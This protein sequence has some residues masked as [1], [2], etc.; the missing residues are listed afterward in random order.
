MRIFYFGILN[1]TFYTL[2]EEFLKNS[3]EAVE[4]GQQH[5]SFTNLLESDLRNSVI[6]IFGEEGLL[7]LL[8]VYLNELK[9]IPSLDYLSEIAVN[10]LIGLRNKGCC[11]CFTPSSYQQKSNPSNDDLFSAL[12]KNNNQDLLKSFDLHLITTQYLNELVHTDLNF[13]LFRFPAAPCVYNQIHGIAERISLLHI[14][15]FHDEEQRTLM[16]KVFVH[17]AS[18]YKKV[19]YEIAN[20]VSSLHPLEV[21]EKL[22]TSNI[23]IEQ[24]PSYSSSNNQLSASHQFGPLALDAMNHGRAV[25]GSNPMIHSKDYFQMDIAPVINCNLQNFDT[26]LEAVVKEALCLKDYS[27]RCRQYAHTHHNVKNICKKLLSDYSKVIAAAASKKKSPS[28]RYDTDVLT[29]NA[30]P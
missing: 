24:F 29:M 23:F 26:K 14:P 20:P 18:K 25:L 19:T 4:C 30:R 9:Q 3:V 16:K 17:L 5:T 11:I 15:Y 27:I 2:Q 8:K 12:L 1:T 21:Q 10:V 6:H 7:S 22:T 13:D 28:K